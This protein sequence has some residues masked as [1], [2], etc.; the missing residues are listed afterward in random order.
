MLTVSIM[1]DKLGNKFKE[2]TSQ[3][4]DWKMS[5]LH[6][7]G[8]HPSPSDVP[9]QIAQTMRR[10]SALKIIVSRREVDIQLSKS[11]RFN[12]LYYV[13]IHDCPFKFQSAMN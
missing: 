7:H 10:R 4:G 11:K 12:Y 5:F 6:G 13:I 3:I 2:L 1:K 9:G 8:T